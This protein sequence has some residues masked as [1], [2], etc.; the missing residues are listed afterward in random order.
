MLVWITIIFTALNGQ[1][2]TPDGWYPQETAD[3]EDCL[4]KVDRT[5]EYFK[6]LQN[7]PEY[8]LACVEAPTQAD[9]LKKAYVQYEEGK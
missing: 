3:M 5:H 4:M 1:T 7:V 2:Y 6:R 9:A 8:T